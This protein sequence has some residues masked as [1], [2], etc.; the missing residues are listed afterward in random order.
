MLSSRIAFALVFILDFFC[1]R[2]PP[3]LRDRRHTALN[4]LLKVLWYE[5][6]IVSFI[7]MKKKGDKKDETLNRAVSARPLRPSDAAR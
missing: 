2:F 6:A 1:E 4:I 7:T 5:P 3:R